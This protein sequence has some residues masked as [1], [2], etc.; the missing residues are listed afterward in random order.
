VLSAREQIENL[1]QI[2]E[3]SSL[4]QGARVPLIEVLGSVLDPRSE[5]FECQGLAI[6][7]NLLAAKSP[8]LIA[9]PLAAQLR[10]DVTRI[11]AV[12]SCAAG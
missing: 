5:A 9:E 11:K 12:M 10:F 1:I 2:L 8:A 6:F 3:S 7:L 4:V